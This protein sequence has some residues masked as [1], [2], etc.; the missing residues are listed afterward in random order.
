MHDITGL[1][2]S[3]L[4]GFQSPFLKFVCSMYPFWK[5]KTRIVI[6]KYFRRWIRIKAFSYHALYVQ[7][8]EIFAGLLRVSLLNFPR[9]LKGRL[10]EFKIAFHNF[11]SKTSP[12]SAI[13]FR[14]SAWCSVLIHHLLSLS[15]RSHNEIVARI[16]S[17]NKTHAARNL[18]AACE[19]ACVRYS[20]MLQCATQ[21]SFS[22]FVQSW[23]KWQFCIQ[24][25]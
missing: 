8:D 21:S 5:Y 4:F 16:I 1:L 3:S 11:A 19:R 7:T 20:L 24:R 15:S 25:I 18:H 12:I 2:Q 13:T 22:Q 17:C 9:K 6:R 10:A 14:E 23:Q